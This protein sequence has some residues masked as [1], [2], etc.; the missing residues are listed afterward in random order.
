MKEMG[1]RMSYFDQ[2][3]QEECNNFFQCFFITILDLKKKKKRKK[4][5]NQDLYQD[6]KAKKEKSKTHCQVAKNLLS[7]KKTNQVFKKSLNFTQAPGLC[8]AFSISDRIY[9]NSITKLESRNA[10]AQE[11]RKGSK[12]CAQ[13]A[14]TGLRTPS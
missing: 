12:L 11:E 4:I 6:Q 2:G 10:V 13:L 1:Y 9:C 8:S 3:H 7:K 5:I 14:L